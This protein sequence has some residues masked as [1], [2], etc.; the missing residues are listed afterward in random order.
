MSAFSF[1]RTGETEIGV[2]SSHCSRKSDDSVRTNNNHNFFSY[3]T[4][5]RISLC[6]DEGLKQKITFKT[7]FSS[8]VK[9]HMSFTRTETEFLAACSE[10]DYHKVNHMFMEDYDELDL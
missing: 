1:P 4:K 3:Y 10:G 2:Y 5:K 9:N 8:L 7:S 6:A